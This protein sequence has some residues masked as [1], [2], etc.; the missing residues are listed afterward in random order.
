MDFV[1][2][3]E[4]GQG[5]FTLDNQT[6]GAKVEVPGKGTLKI[7]TK[8][9][10]YASSTSSIVNDIEYEIKHDIDFQHMTG[11]ELA[12]KGF[13]AIDDL[14]SVSMS[15]EN[16]W[17]GRLRMYF[18]IG[19]DNYPVYGFTESADNYDATVKGYTDAGAKQETPVYA[20]LDGRGYA[21]FSTA[22]PIKRHLLVPSKLTEEAAKTMFAPLVLWNTAAEPA[23][24]AALGD[25][26]PA[27]KFNEGIGLICTGVKGDAQSGSIAV[28]NATLSFDGLTDD[29][30]VVVS[31]IDNYGGGSLHPQFAAGTDPATAKAEY[32]ASHIG[33]VVSTV[34]GTETF[35]LYRIDTALSR[36]LVLTPKNATGIETI[37]YNKVVSDQN[38]PV[39]NLNGVQVNPNALQKGIYIKQGKKFIVR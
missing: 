24:G 14:N 16:C 15:G 31:K 5:S 19:S 39:Y 37:N 36:V 17:T 10:G 32:K 6:S 20:F 33:G 27:V 22:E 38:A 18:S 9:L 13:T 35:Q 34:K 4:G 30:L 25:D 28:N 11:A 7:T 3:G 21:D 2:E 29:D 12:E 23:E 26:V 1:F 8:A